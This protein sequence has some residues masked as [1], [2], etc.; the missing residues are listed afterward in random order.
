VPI[1]EYECK[2]HR[3]SIISLFTAI[4]P[5]W[6][7]SECRRMA[8]DEN[9]PRHWLTLLAIQGERAVGQTNL[10][11]LDSHHRLGNIGYH[12]HPGFQRK[13]IGS[14]LL[15][16]V[17]PRDINRFKDGIVIQTTT[18]NHGSIALARKAGFIP[19]PRSLVKRHG[20]W[21]KSTRMSK[22]VCLHLPP[23]QHPQIT[24][25]MDWAASAQRLLDEKGD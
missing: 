19:A 13:G 15:S 6:S 5:Q 14:L 8:Y 9:Q 1:V 11:S 4:Y 22:G 20:R 21:L 18:D 24:N 17:D 16:R 23:N 10:F 12:V 3:E 2:R 25:L 7:A